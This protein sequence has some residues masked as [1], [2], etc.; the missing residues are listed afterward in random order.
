[1]SPSPIEKINSLSDS[2]FS[3]L[4]LCAFLILAAIFFHF[5]ATPARTG[6]AK[7]LPSYEDGLK[8]EQRLDNVLTNGPRAG[9]SVQE[10]TTN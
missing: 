10:K 6:G 7:N 1:M 4:K 3:G 8:T 9:L 5:W 2:H